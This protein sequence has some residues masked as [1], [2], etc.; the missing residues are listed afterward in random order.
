MKDSE[1]M[2]TKILVA[3]VG[4]ATPDCMVNTKKEIKTILEELS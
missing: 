3:M 4:L 1:T 2:I